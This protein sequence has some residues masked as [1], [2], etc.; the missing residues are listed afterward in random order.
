LSSAFKAHRMIAEIISI[1][2][3]L[4]SGQRLDT[5]SQWLSARLSDL[6]V[7]VVYHTTVAD[8][9][10]ANVR[11]FQ[12]AIH[13]A[14]LVVASGGLGPTA[15]D[16][17]RDALAAAA[18]VPLVLDD[19][20]LAHI[21]SLFAQHNREMPERNRLQAMFPAGSRPIPNAAG[22]APGID[23]VVER[24]GLGNS[25]V[26]AL[27]GVP[28]E[29]FEMFASWVAPAVTAMQP[30][31][32]V[33][34][35]RRIKCFGAGESQVEQMLPNLIRRGREPSVG[36]TVHAATITLRITAE[37]RTAEE[38]QAATQPTIDTIHECLGQLVFGEEDDELE[39]AVARLL[40]ERQQSLSTV[41]LG[42]A[43]LMAQWLRRATQAAPAPLGSGYRGGLVLCGPDD[44]VK[45]L[46]IE[47]PATNSAQ[48]VDDRSGRQPDGEAFA[49]LAALACREKFATD[50]ALSV[51]SFPSAAI[52]PSG[53]AAH[54]YFALAMADKVIC[55]SGTL[56]SHPDIWKPRAAKQ[57][58]NL[59]RLAL[60]DRGSVS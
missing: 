21:R 42:T 18:G 13:R 44:A 41:E 35:H 36:I 4:T 8:D 47:P 51:G 40:A 59:L 30:E 24:A 9:L 50:F 3:E 5:N 12:T 6:G 15:D 10:D 29:M 39:D 25:R 54:Y 49:R 38:C 11:V 55:R 48:G 31:P 28:A 22:T 26:F 14:E 7:R 37:G 43:G 17:T 60:I 23:L 45:A 56:I 53:A 27:P 34:R 16:L 32:R 57:T 52:E 58:L 19:A 2:D 20:S 1:G 33:I 46:G